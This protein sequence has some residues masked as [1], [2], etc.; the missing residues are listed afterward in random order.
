MYK[1]LFNNF[2]L[3]KMRI[4]SITEKMCCV[5]S[6]VMYILWSYYGLPTLDSV[7]SR[8]IHSQLDQYNRGLLHSSIWT[9]KVAI[10][11]LKH[12]WKL[13]HSPVLP[14]STKALIH[15]HYHFCEISGYFSMG[16]ANSDTKKKKRSFSGQKSAELKKRLLFYLPA[17]YP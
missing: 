5:H 16:G 9:W 6:Y 11:M 15:A 13:I 1:F 2:K 10:P 4:Y 3:S 8:Q 7:H 14:L 12:D 17:F